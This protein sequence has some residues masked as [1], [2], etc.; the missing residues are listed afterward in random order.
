M[1]IIDLTVVRQKR[2]DV[3]DE[4]NNAILTYVVSSLAAKTAIMS[5]DL[6]SCLYSI[7]IG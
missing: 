4:G 6:H 3:T 1:Q 2:D 5:L 7:F